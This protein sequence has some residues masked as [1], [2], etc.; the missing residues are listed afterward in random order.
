VK[1]TLNVKKRDVNFIMEK[2]RLIKDNITNPVKHY[3]LEEAMMRLMDTDK[4]YPN[5]IRLRR[6]K[7]S[8]LIGFLETP[9]DTVNVEFAKN[10]GVKILRRHNLGGTVYQDLG[11]FMFTV[12][13][14]TGTFISL[15]TEEEIYKDFSD[16]IILFLSK[17]GIKGQSRGVNDVVV[18]GRKIFGSA[19]TMIGD[20]VS[21][22][23]SVL[24]N[25]DLEFL[26]KLLKFVEPKFS[27]K[28]FKSIGDALT[29]ISI[30][31]GRKIP[32]FEI[33]NRFLSSFQEKFNVEL[34]EDK[35]KDKELSLTNQFVKEKYG[36]EEWTF[37]REIEYEE[38]YTKKVI[39]GLIF[40]KGIFKKDFIDKIKISGD[41]LAK[42]GE[43]IVKLE[44]SVRGKSF[45]NVEN[46]IS[47]FD[48]PQDIKLGLF[49]L[50]K[51]I[52][53]E[54]K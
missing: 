37:S 4:L 10:H 6:V 15:K 13:F 17:Y 28:K 5:T 50:I 53:K 45:E 52:K 19:H 48:L 25:M 46:I 23:G 7:K 29:T 2:F 30:E 16:F 51:E 47:N 40:I 54:H 11:N 42:T 26:S 14:R 18:N 32:I 9:F 1:Q 35:L 38:V 27:D 49:E 43:E 33:Y 44:K 22:T 8:V 3:A 34:F 31:S 41:F 24:V 20:A 36:K 12:L 39:S 21:H